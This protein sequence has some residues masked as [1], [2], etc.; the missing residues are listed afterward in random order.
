M[1]FMGLFIGYRNRHGFL[2]NFCHVNI[3]TV[4]MKARS[5]TTEKKMLF[6]CVIDSGA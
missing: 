1:F 2:H 3:I 6:D 4:L 5:R